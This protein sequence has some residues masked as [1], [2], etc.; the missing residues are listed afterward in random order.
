MNSNEQR[1]HDFALMLVKIS[2]E[3]SIE[4]AKLSGKTTININGDKILD[5]YIDIYNQTLSRLD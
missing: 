5:S 3:A 2:T 4:S 1:A